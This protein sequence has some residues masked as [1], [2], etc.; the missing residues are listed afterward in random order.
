MQRDKKTEEH[1]R[2]RKML[3]E[4]D[5]LSRA[6]RDTGEWVDVEPY[7]R[8]WIRYYVLRDDAK[9]RKDAR[10]MQQVLDKINTEVHCNNERFER[11][12]WKTGKM[13]PIPQKPKYLTTEQYNDLTE[14]QK[15]FFVKHDWVEITM[16]GGYKQ[17]RFVSGYVFEHS[18]YLVFKKEPNIV[19]QHWIP[20]Q[21]IESRFGELKE[22]MQRNNLWA[23]MN[24]AMHWNTGAKYWRNGL[25]YKYRNADGFEFEDFDDDPDVKRLRG[26][27]WTDD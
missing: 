3:K 23:K 4:Y 19:T 17:K 21:E 25:P 14:K 7:Q 27:D 9:N 12:N 11:R 2:L 6:R 10:E 5:K 26:H 22:H 24:K 20:N 8:G 13:E 18:Y 15:S 16:Y 1:K